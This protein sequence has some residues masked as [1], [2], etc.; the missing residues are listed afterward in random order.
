MTT[1]EAFKI[2]GVGSCI[3][4]VLGLRNL[5]RFYDPHSCYLTHVKFPWT[6]VDS[7]FRAMYMITWPKVRSTLNNL[8]HSIYDHDLQVV[9]T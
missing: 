9:T 4:T 8:V 3:A 7:V 5:I 2:N 1:H 6:C